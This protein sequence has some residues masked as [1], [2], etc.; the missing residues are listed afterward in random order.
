MSLLV[1][2]SKVSAMW[3]T[4]TPRVEMDGGV[5]ASRL[6]YRTIKALNPEDVPEQVWIAGDSETVLASREKDA[7]FF[8]E[9]YGNR[10][11]E[12]YDFMDE[13]KKMTK[14]GNDG[15]WWHVKSEDNAADRASRLD[16]TPAD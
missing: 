7:G 12:T 11:G 15:E 2:K 10:I 3:S 14:V 9:F 6:T 13:I 8:G 5:M 4:S 16:S 1:A